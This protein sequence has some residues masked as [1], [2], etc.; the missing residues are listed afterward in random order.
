MKRLLLIL[1]LPI[2]MASCKKEPA[3]QQQFCYKCTY[4]TVKGYTRP[5][6]TFC[7]DLNNYHPM[8]GPDEIS[9]SCH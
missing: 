3:T 8:Y 4:G 5:D 2:L 7:G 6:D 1:A 9:F